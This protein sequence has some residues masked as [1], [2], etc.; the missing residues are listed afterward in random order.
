[1]KRIPIVA[2][3]KRTPFVATLI[4]IA[5]GVALAFALPAG[6]AVSQQS[7]PVAAIQIAS[8]A[9]LGARGAAVTVPV[10]VVCGPNGTIF[11]SVQVTQRAGSEIASGSGNVQ[12]VSCTGSFQTINVNVPANSGKA[13]KKGKAFASA[14]FFICNAFGCTNASDA[15][16]IQID[17]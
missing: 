15:R 8:P 3:I 17:R 16:E 11:V 13:F 5:A 6:A 1:M 10:T 12:N 7:P 4:A 2:T 9:H 14:D